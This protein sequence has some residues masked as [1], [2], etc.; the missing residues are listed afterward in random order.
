MS[1]FKNVDG[2]WKNF[3]GIDLIWITGLEDTMTKQIDFYIYAR[4][5]N[6]SDEYQ[7]FYESFD[8][9]SSAETFLDVFMGK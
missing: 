5:I 9:L 3:D 4:D 1:N 8:S 6:E 7:L 2:E